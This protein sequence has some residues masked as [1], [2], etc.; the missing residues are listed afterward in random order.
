MNT[1]SNYKF[2]VKLYT[3]GGEYIII[4]IPKYCITIHILDP[5][6]RKFKP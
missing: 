6:K 4:V 1:W 5:K 3:S 2:N